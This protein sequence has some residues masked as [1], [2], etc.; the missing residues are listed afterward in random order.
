MFVKSINLSCGV[1]GGNIFAGKSEGILTKTQ[2]AEHGK[3]IMIT[4]WWKVLV[5]K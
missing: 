1:C 2:S 3:S 5:K 4:I